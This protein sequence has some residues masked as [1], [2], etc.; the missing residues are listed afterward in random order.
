VAFVGG[1]LTS[2]LLTPNP[3]GATT[4]SP[5]NAS[6][7]VRSFDGEIQAVF[8]GTSGGILFPGED[9]FYVQY[10]G[11]GSLFGNVDVLWSLASEAETF[12]RAEILS[13]SATFVTQVPEPGAFALLNLGLLGILIVRRRRDLPNAAAYFAMP[14]AAAPL[15]TAAGPSCRVAFGVGHAR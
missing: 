12:A 10:E 6:I 15:A 7:S 9:S 14:W 3:L 11:I 4:F 2:L 1:P 5:A 13:G 8:V